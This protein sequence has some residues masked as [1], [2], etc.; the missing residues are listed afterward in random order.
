MTAKECI[1]TRRSIR[2]FSD[3]PVDEAVLKDIIETASFLRS[4]SVSRLLNMFFRNC[5]S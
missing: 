5:G 3:K 2:Q 4:I 1:M